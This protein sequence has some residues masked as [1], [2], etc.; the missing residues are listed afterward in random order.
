M[1]RG[2]QVCFSF[3]HSISTKSDNGIYHARTCSGLLTR[4]VKRGRN[5]IVQIAEERIRLL[6]D[7][8]KGTFKTNPE[9]S[10]RYVELARRIGMRSRVRV[11]GELKYITCHNCFSLLIPG[12]SCRVR[13]RPDRGTDVVMTC[14]ACNSVKRYPA[15]RERMRRKDIKRRKTN[16]HF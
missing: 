1:L 7:M 13:I 6:Y 16:A 4:T 3:S 10:R 5:S 8:A 15:S 11:P 2:E 14:L 9:M 12:V